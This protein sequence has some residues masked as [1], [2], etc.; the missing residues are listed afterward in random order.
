MERATRKSAMR[1]R[2]ASF[3]GSALDHGNHFIKEAFARFACYPHND[4]IGKYGSTASYCASIAACLTDNGCG[5]AC[6][7]AF[8]Y[9]SGSLNNLTVARNL[10]SC[11]HNDN[12]AFL[13]NAEETTVICSF[14]SAEGILCASTSFLKLSERPP[15]PCLC[16]R[17]SLRQNWQKYR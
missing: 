2:L 6:D 17:Q 8:V 15:A 14:L 9:G 11:F 3:T 16:P 5:F 7:S 1:F 10:L 4:P 13:S 12:V